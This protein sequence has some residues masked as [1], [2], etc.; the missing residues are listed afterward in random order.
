V[1]SRRYRP[2]AEY[3]FRVVYEVDPQ[4]KRTH[5]YLTTR[6]GGQGFD[7]CD[8]RS[9]AATLTCGKTLIATIAALTDLV[10]M[11]A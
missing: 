7:S 6:N 1:N 8:S 4:G 5:W 3:I 10:M 2:G 11:A 9:F